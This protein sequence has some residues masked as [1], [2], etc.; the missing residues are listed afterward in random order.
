MEPEKTKRLGKQNMTRMNEKHASE[1]EKQR[2]EMTGKIQQREK[3]TSEIDI[4]GR[5]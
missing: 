1:T 2:R 5:K 3:C 4:V